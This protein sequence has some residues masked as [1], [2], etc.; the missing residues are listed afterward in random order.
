MHVLSSVIN[1][2]VL[3]C[4]DVSIL[5][6]ALLAAAGLGGAAVV[7]RSGQGAQGGLAV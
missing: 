7:C 3:Q 2:Q 6:H 4:D 1:V 5:S